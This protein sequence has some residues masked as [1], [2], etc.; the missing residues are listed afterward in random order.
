MKYSRIDFKEAHNDIRILY[1]GSKQYNQ[2]E[3]NEAQSRLSTLLEYLRFLESLNG[4]IGLMNRKVEETRG[5]WIKITGDLHAVPI[6]N[7]EKEVGFKIE[8]D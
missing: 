1:Q 4:P 2:Q 7:N 3:I 6:F 8:S 5:H